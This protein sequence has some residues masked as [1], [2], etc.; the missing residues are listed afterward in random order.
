MP[1]LEAKV[2]KDTA[3]HQPTIWVCSDCGYPFR[4]MYEADQPGES[5][6]AKM[7]GDFTEHCKQLHHDTKI[8]SL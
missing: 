6:L 4:V 5:Q 2:F 8:A 3:K 7:N 1:R